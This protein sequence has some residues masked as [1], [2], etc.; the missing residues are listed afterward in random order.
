MADYQDTD[1]IL[2]VKVFS[3]KDSA[4]NFINICE[5]YDTKYS[6]LLMPKPSKDDIESHG[7]S[8]AKDICNLSEEMQNYKNHIK[9]FF[10]NHPTK[11][12]SK[13]QFYSYWIEELELDDQ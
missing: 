9:E 5:K 6:D 8:I 2:N 11:D 4:E 12:D 10:E 3:S 7:W 13:D 1:C